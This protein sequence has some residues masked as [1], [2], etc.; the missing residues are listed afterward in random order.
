MNENY[1]KCS[2]CGYDLDE[3]EMKPCP[4]CGKPICEECF[5]QGLHRCFTNADTEWR[6]IEGFDEMD[7][8]FKCPQ[9]GEEIS[10]D[11]AFFSEYLDAWVCLD[12][13]IE[14][15]HLNEDWMDDDDDEND[16]DYDEY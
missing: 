4:K 14:T 16:E 3:I 11:E 6:D 8:F 1:I 15:E 5:M 9:C 10:E 2:E 7:A 13:H 12:C